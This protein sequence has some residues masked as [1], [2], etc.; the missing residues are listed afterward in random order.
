MPMQDCT[1]Q[2]TNSTSV[3]STRKWKKLAREVGQCVLSP[4]PMI[5]DRRPVLED[6]D[7]SVG[8]K[9]CWNGSSYLNK[10]NCEVAARS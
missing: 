9:Q 5:V 8:K 2:V 6:V 7:R 4:S 3:G 10:E 1:N